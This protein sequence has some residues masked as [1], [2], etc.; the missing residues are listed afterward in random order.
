MI[1]SGKILEVKFTVEDPD[2]FYAPWSAI[3]A[4]SPRAD[5]DDRASLCRE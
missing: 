1:E 3:A 2:T 5:H 4:L